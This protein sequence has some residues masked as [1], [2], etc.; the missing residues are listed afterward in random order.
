M[1]GVYMSSKKQEVY[2]LFQEVLNEKLSICEKTNY[3]KV[4]PTIQVRLSEGQS[5]LALDNSNKITPNIYSIKNK[6]APF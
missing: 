6:N 1:E 2:R 3:F 4:K 5:S